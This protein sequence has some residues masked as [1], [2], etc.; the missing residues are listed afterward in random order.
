MPFPYQQP[1][2][3]ALW[4]GVGHRTCNPHAISPY[5][6]IGEKRGHSEDFGSDS[7][8]TTSGCTATRTDLSSTTWSNTSTRM[9]RSMTISS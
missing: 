9:A 7:P 4:I 5:T 3:G 1:P 6:W 8:P 2:D